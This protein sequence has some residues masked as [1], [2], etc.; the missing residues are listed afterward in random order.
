MEPDQ[1]PLASLFPNISAQLRSALSNL[2]LAAAQLAPASAIII[3]LN[4][5]ADLEIPLIEK[6]R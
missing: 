2:H 3:A 6:W 1:N 4:N 5:L